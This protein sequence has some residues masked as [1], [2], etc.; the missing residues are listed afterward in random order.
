MYFIAQEYI[1]EIYIL[2][3]NVP[4]D[5][6]ATLLGKPDYL[7]IHAMIQINQS[8]QQHNA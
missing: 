3:Y 4:T 5:S 7:L 1:L 2:G 6:P 8:W